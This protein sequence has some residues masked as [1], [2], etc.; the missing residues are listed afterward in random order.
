MEHLKKWTP[1]V[2]KHGLLIIELHTIDPKYASEFQGE[3]P[4]TAYDATHGFTDQYIV[5]ISVFDA[6]AEETGL[7]LDDN[8]SRTFPSQE[9]SSVSLR[10]FKAH[11]C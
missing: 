2:L 4:V 6:I 7:V 11:N 8:W 10:Y 1:Y 5:E 3:L 9:P